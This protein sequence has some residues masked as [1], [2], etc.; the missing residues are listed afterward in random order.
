[1]GQGTVFCLAGKGEEFMRKK[2]LVILL[3]LAMI[4]L[5]GCGLSLSSPNR[6]IE[7]YLKSKYNSDFYFV[8]RDGYDVRTHETNYTYKDTAGN[9]FKVTYDKYG[10]ADNYCHILYDEA[11]Q[12]KLQ[13]ILGENCKVFVS[14]ELSFT[15]ASSNVSSVEDYMGGVSVS[16]NVEVYILQKPDYQQIAKDLLSETD[17]VSLSVFVFHVTE[18]GY[19]RVM[20][21]LD[22]LNLADELGRGYFRIE[23]NEIKTMDWEE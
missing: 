14:T 6:K 5:S 12:N 23:D 8:S 4:G 21:Y 17:G 18:N 10:V 19:D 11:I 7:S 1:M 9:N 15:V 13:S 2:G 16:T 3:L 20:K 22:S